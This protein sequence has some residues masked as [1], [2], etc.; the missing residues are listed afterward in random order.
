MLDITNLFLK[1]SSSSKDDPFYMESYQ[2]EAEEKIPPS[3]HVEVKPGV[4]DVGP[5]QSGPPVSTGKLDASQ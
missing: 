5:V 3:S 2:P 4:Q 1:P